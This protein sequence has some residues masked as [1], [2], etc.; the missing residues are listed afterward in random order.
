MQAIRVATTNM[1][2]PENPHKSQ[3]TQYDSHST[4]VRPNARPNTNMVSGGIWAL[5]VTDHCQHQDHDEQL[6]FVRW[7]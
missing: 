1:L 6:H 3:L 7:L 4:N 2:V 5:Q